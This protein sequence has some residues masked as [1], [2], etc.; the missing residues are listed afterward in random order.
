[1]TGERNFWEMIGKHWPT[2]DL[3]IN[4][5]STKLLSMNQSQRNYNLKLILASAAAVLELLLHLY[6][7]VFPLLLCIY[8]SLALVSKSRTPPSILT[9]YIVLFRVTSYIILWW[10]MDN[11]M[12][13][14]WST[15]WHPTEPHFWKQW[16]R[17]STLS[18]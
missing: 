3:L 8:C 17:T 14:T 15:R 2:E 9:R 10:M 1:M 11:A 18:R 16:T 7:R 6:H 4:D 5:Q 12:Q 13:Q